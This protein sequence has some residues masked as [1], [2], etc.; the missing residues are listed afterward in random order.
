VSEY[1]V[2][3]ARFDDLDARTGYALW[4]LRESVFVVEQ[5]CA[6]QELDGL[7]LEPSTLHAWVEHAGQ[8]VAYLRI[9]DDAG[10]ARIGRVLVTS[11][12]RG[13]GLAAQLMR[14][15]LE[16]IG[17]RP[18]GLNAQTY[19]AGWYTTFGFTQVGPEFL[20]D[21]IPHVPMQR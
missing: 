10:Q 2:R 14:R 17:D 21:G 12:H 11:A 16:E 5:A 15:A 7:D 18:A 3:T 13:R 8:P 9:V 4:Q 6:Y 1:D 20:E 19:L